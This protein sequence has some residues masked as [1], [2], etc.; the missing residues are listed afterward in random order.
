L[1]V[2]AETAKVVRERARH[3]CQFCLLGEYQPG[4]AS[5]WRL[6]LHH[7]AAGG[8]GGTRDPGHDLPANLALLHDF[9]HRVIVHGNPREAR[10]LGLL[11]SR[12]GKIRP[13]ALLRRPA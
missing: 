9:C 1:A 8:K 2:T 12:L 3:R 13:S 10:A 6:V 7:I 5:D 4:P 11:A